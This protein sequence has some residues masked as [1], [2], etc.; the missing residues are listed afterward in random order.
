M[1]LAAQRAVLHAYA[2]AAGL[3]EDHVQTARRCLAGAIDDL[4]RAALGWSLY[5]GFT[6]VA[7]AAAHVDRLFATRS[8]DPPSFAHG[9][10]DQ[11]LADLL[12]GSW[13]YSYDLISGLVGLGVYAL[14]RGTQGERL[15]RTV[16]L[17]LK[18]QSIPVQNGVTWR[19]R[20]A[21]MT[22]LQRRHF[23][24][25]HV[26]LSVSHGVGGVIGLL[27]DVSTASSIT[28]PTRHL[29]EC[30]TAWLVT[31]ASSDPRLPTVT[32][33][34]ATASRRLAWCSGDLSVALSLLA[35]A[36]CL[37]REEWVSLAMRTI[38]SLAEVRPQSPALH[39][40]GCATVH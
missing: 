12:N 7:W 27:A 13:M 5:G 18:Q 36:H 8:T 35:S 26:D 34:G 19:L 21:Q 22:S 17:L 31:Q 32:G 9:D 14:E 20:R 15:L 23:G 39:N 3:G 40:L 24:D 38:R 2:G 16:L 33:A 37:E 6:E 30:G 25:H 29:L 11:A 28:H 1:L 4:P 10:I